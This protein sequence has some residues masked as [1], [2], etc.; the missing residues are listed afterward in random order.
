M[1]STFARIATVTAVLSFVGCMNSEPVSLTSNAQHQV[2][3]ASAGGNGKGHYPNSAKYKVS[4]IKSGTGRAGSASLEVRALI[5]QNG[6][7][8]IE[9]TTGSL[10]AGT[11]VGNIDKVQVKVLSAT[12]ATT[13]FNKLNAGGYWTKSYNPGLSR[14][15]KVQVQANVSGI[16]GKRTDVVTATA[17]A[18]RRPDIAVNSVNGP[19]QGLPNAAITFTAALS[20]INGDVGATANCILSVN[21]SPVDQ[22]NGIWIDANGTVSCMFSYQFDAAG[23]YSVSVAATNVNPGDWDLANNSSSTSIT[24][25]TPGNPIASGYLQSVNY[26]YNYTNRS[27]NI[28]GNFP[29]LD[30]TRQAYS[31]SYISMSGQ[32]YGQSVGGLQSVSANISV[33]GNTVHSVTLTANQTSVYDDGSYFQNCGSYDGMISQVGNVYVHDGNWAQICAYG[34]HN[35]PGSNYTSYNYQ[36]VSGSVVYYSRNINSYY[37]QDNTYTYDNLYDSGV[38]DYGTTVG[39][40]VRAQLNLVDGAGVSHTIDHSVTMSQGPVWNDSSTSDWYYYEL[41]ETIRQKTHNWG[42]QI[43]GAYSW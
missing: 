24:I 15:T 1:N 25:Q 33:D 17:T 4:G 29:Y 30:E 8:Q 23:T 20:E 41:G 37:G 43:F 7:T 16:D 11:S 26:S 35:Q 9:A 42:S 5:A 22:S 28:N 31:Y 40:I 32:E 12:T 27:E 39:S 34:Y 2:T 38:N 19:A 18:A 21:G 14:G 3:S 10:E 36:H 6:S 13:N